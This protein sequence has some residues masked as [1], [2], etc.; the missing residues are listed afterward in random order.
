MQYV[1]IPGGPYCSIIRV[2]R[3][4]KYDYSKII[5]QYTIHWSSLYNWPINI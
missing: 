1:I 2:S 4:S 3:C 5:L